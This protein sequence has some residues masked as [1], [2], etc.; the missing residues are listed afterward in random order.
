M[1]VLSACLDDDRWLNKEDAIDR[2]MVAQLTQASFSFYLT[3][4]SIAQLKD[5]A[6]DPG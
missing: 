2:A 3:C 4:R 6:V 1:D 5:A